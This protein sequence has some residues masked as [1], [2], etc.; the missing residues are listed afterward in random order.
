MIALALAVLAFVYLRG[1][2]RLR[3]TP[4]APIPSWRAGSFVLGLVLVW[5]AAGS[6]IAS[7]DEGSLTMHMVQHL[8]LMTMAPLLIFL[9][10]P[11][12]ALG[13]GLPR[14][15]EAVV[16]GTARWPGLQWVGSALGQPAFCWLAATMTLVGWHIPA[17]FTLA[18][19]SHGWH[20]VEQA[21][22][23]G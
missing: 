3:S 18:L 5:I 7:C 8:L 17:A 20:V 2:L 4:P 16:A 10:E 13:R 1:W 22:F 14:L 12:K 23:L 19:N 11:L 9:G 21:T 6:R 15:T